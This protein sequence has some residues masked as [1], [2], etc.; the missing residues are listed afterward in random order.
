[1]RV[2]LT[3]LFVQLA[4]GSVMTSESSSLSA[5]TL[6]E[7]EG[8]AVSSI[9]LGNFA[10]SA[11]DVK[12]LPGMGLF[13][14]AFITA[15]SFNSTT[16]QCTVCITIEP[17]SSQVRCKIGLRGVDGNLLKNASFGMDDLSSVYSALETTLTVMG[18]DSKYPKKL[19]GYMSEAEEVD[20]RRAAA[21]AEAS[22]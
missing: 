16:A 8:G 21:E 18:A 10:T 15:G 19:Q 2:L 17:T 1:M 5:G 12:P 4:A 14:S 6:Y 22:K 13:H 9:P 20:A 11:L 7:V 3:A